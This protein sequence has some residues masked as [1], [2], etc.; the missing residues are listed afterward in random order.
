MLLD[1]ISLVNVYSLFLSLTKVY[2]NFVTLINMCL[3]LMDSTSTSSSSTTGFMV[4]FYPSRDVCSNIPG[5]G[6][7]VD[8]VDTEMVEGVFHQSV[9]VSE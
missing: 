6:K 4:V 2:S 3:G 9:E 7:L 5:Y 1:Q 8:T